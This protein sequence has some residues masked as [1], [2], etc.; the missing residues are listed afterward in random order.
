EQL[1]GEHDTLAVIEVP[2]G[3]VWETAMSAFL[4]QLQVLFERAVARQ[5]FDA[6]ARDHHVVGGEVAQRCCTADDGRRACGDG[7]L[8]MPQSSQQTNLFERSDLR[9]LIP[10]D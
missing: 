2:V 1:L 6:G 10:L 7:A 5:E 4:D 9:S 3:A 8:G